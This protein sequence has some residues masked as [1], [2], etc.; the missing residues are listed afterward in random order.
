MAYDSP[1]ERTWI[2]ASSHEP[3]GRTKIAR[4][5]SGRRMM[6]MIANPKDG[7]IALRV[8]MDDD[9]DVGDDGRIVNVS[10]QRTFC[11]G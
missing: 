4:G 5:E 7:W 9:Y 11:G 10:C 2:Y 6:M 3:R 1:D 8:M